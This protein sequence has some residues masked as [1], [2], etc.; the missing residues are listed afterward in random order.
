MAK[1]RLV[2]GPLAGKVMY[3]SAQPGQTQIVVRSPKPMSR[4][5]RYMW[6]M[7]A[8]RARY[9]YVVGTGGNIQSFQ[10]TPFPQI[11]AQY[12]ISM[13][14]YQGMMIPCQHPDGSYFYE[15]VADSKKEF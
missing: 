6:S 11:E 5:Q 1:V 2:R 8:D 12:K 9:N 15:Y 3:I 14:M 10:P 13:T 7:K 4:K